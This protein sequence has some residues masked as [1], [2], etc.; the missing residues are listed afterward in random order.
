[1]DPFEGT[2]VEVISNGEVLTLYNDPDDEPS[3]DP[4]VRQRYV[5]AVT[6]ATFEVRVCVDR[7]FNLFSLGRNDAVSATIYYD[8]T[9]K[10]AKN[11]LVDA[12]LDD[13]RVGGR[14]SRTFTHI[15]NFCPKTGQWKTG[16]TT[17]GA[18]MTSE[19]KYEPVNPKPF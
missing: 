19:P 13:S 8:S 6:G 11:F 12:L 9:H 1:M 3:H 7:R 18:L 10:Y 14:V 2:H 15:H 5:E 4:R 16:D 17:F